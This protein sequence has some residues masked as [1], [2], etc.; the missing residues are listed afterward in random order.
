MDVEA[1]EHGDRVVQ[2]IRVL[3]RWARD[4]KVSGAGVGAEVPDLTGGTVVGA[5]VDD[6]EFVVV[7]EVLG[8]EPDL[9]LRGPRHV[10]LDARDEKVGHR[11]TL[12]AGAL[13]RHTMWRG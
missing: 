11:P 12:S 3:V 7:G 4:A 5:V 13:S 10:V 6:D 2:A 1:P 9:L 8:E